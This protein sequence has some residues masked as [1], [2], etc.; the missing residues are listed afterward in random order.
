MDG[1]SA[2]DQPLDRKD[3]KECVRFAREIAPLKLQVEGHVGHTIYRE[4]L[5]RRLETPTE[6]R[7]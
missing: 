6:Q 3:W 2:K 5:Y 7:A 1:L 4:A